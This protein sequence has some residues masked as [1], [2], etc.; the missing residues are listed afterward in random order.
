MKPIYRFK[1]TREYSTYVSF[2]ADTQEDAEKMLDQF[3]D[4]GEFAHQELEQ[5]N[6]DNEEITLLNQSK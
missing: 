1:I 6:V 2:L 4:S 3:I 5:M